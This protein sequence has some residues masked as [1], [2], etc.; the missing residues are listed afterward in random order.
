MVIGNFGLSLE[1]SKAQMTIW[2]IWAAPLIM[3]VDLRTIKPEFKDILLNKHAIK[4]NQDSLGIQ[5]HLH[6]TVIRIY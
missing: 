2:S 4:I 5:G 3:S 6:T 1:Q